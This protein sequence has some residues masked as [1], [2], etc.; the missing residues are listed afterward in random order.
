MILYLITQLIVYG[1]YTRIKE[2]KQDKGVTHSDQFKLS[3]I[4]NKSSN[5]STTKDT[6]MQ[7]KWETLKGGSQRPSPP[8]NSFSTCFAPVNKAY[9]FG[10]IQVNFI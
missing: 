8:R 7:F 9:V 3:S 10:G 6:I 4:Q 5:E 2:G 1:G